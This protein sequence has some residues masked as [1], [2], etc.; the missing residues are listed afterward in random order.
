M[1]LNMGGD[2]ITEFLY[3][4]LQKIN[5]PYR[6]MDLARAYDWKVMEDIK[7]RLCTLAEVRIPTL[8]ARLS[9]AL[10]RRSQGDVALNLYDFVVRRPGHQTEKYGLRA[11]DETILAPMASLC[12]ENRHYPQLIAPHT[13]PVRAAGH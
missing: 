12:D 13:V 6:D 8:N 7:Y 10:T 2:N 11:Y 4:L 1:S 3:I 9:C 5:F